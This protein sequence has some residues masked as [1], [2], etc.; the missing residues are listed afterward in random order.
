[1]R[2]GALQWLANLCA[3]AAGGSLACASGTLVKIKTTAM[4]LRFVRF[5]LTDCFD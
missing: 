1:M 3:L 2:R 5:A 4:C